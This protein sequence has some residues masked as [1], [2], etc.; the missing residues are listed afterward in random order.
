MIRDPG[1]RVMVCMLFTGCVV[2]LTAAPADVSSHQSICEQLQ[3][4][5]PGLD[6]VGVLGLDWG[7]SR[8]DVEKRLGVKIP[9]PVEVRSIEDLSAPL[10]IS[11]T[12]LRI[13][14]T[15]H[16]GKIAK[17][18]IYETSGA[19]TLA[20]CSDA[21][22]RVADETKS[23]GTK[24]RAVA[25]RW[26]EPDTALTFVVGPKASYLDISKRRVEKVGIPEATLNKLQPGEYVEVEWQES[27]V[28]VARRGDNVIDLLEQV[29][30][31]SPE[32]SQTT[33]QWLQASGL[34]SMNGSRLEFPVLR[35][36]K[37]E[38]AV[39]LLVSPERGCYVHVVKQ[40][41]MTKGFHDPCTDSDYDLSG[42]DKSGESALTVPPHYF[43]EQQGLVIGVPGQ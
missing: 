3:V 10:H 38:F 9:Q 1:I 39:F 31:T 18:T 16:K 42:R 28:V 23:F 2:T 21:F 43:H 33:F 20:R 37:K 15:E 7:M 14:L 11:G 4:E 34:R 27:S 13:G 17:V 36:R 6:E 26:N 29:H 35:S 12:E 8:E 32:E 24:R 25:A 40:D 30:V 19:S 41:D 5:L 22:E